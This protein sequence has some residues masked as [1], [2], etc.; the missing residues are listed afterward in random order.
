MY[1]LMGIQLRQGKLGGKVVQKFGFNPA[2]STD[3]ET[4]WD[5][6]GLYG[7]ISTATTLKVSSSSANDDS[8][9]TGARTVEIF[10]LD[11]NWN[12]VSETI[13]MDGQT[14]V[15]TTETYMRVHRAVVR[16]AGTG[17]TNAG[18]IYVGDG[19]VSSGV[20][21]TKYLKMTAGEGQTLMAL[22]T[23]PAGYTLYLFNATIGTGSTASNKYLE[24]RLKVRPFGEVFQTKVVVT[25]ANGMY[26]HEFDAPLTVPEKSDVEWR[27]HTSSGTDAVTAMFHGIYLP[28]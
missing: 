12:E 23:V 7:Y 11:D 26:K 3:E 9:G 4:V 1:G 22:W 6:G 27:A 5:D 14:A 2:I 24:S 17:E 21:A 20:P 18:D 25:Q 8:A 15:T 16:T 28:A 10:G 19:A 13:T